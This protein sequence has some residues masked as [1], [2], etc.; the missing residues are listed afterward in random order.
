MHLSTDDAKLYY[1]R[2]Y[3][4]VAFKKPMQKTR[5]MVHRSRR[6]TIGVIAGWQFYGTALTMSYLSPIYLGIRQAAHDMGCNLLLACGMG[7]SAQI[8]D[9]PQPAWFAVAEGTNFVPVGPWNTHGLIVINPLQR[10]ER[11]QMV[12]AIRAAGHPIIFVGSGEVGPT[13][14][15]DNTAGIQQALHHLIEHGHR[16]IA[17]IAGSQHDLEGDTGDRLRAFQ[18]GMARFGIEVDPRLI[19]FGNHVFSGGYSAMKRLLATHVPFTAVLASNDESALGAMAALRDHGKRIPDD[20]VII[21]FD[22]R[23]EAL[24]A[25][26]A[27]TSVQIPL[28]KL[29]YQA[30]ELMVRHIRDR[31][32]LPTLIQVPTRLI[33][34]ESCGCSQNA[35]LADTL[36]MITLQ[37]DALAYANVQASVILSMTE[38]LGQRL[39]GF[40]REELTH[41]CQQLLESFLASVQSADPD[42]FR[43][44][45][46]R[47][48][49]QVALTGAD[50]HDWQLAIS[51]LRDVYPRLLNASLHE[52]AQKLLDEARITISSAMRF[53][54]WHYR[55]GQQQISNRVGR[56]TARLL[57]ALAESDIYD[58]LAR[59]LPELQI[60][61]LWIGFFETERDDP[62]AW[63]RLR[64]ITMPQQPVIRIRSRTFPPAQWLDSREPFRLT[65]IPLP[66]V[67]GEAGFVVFDCAQLDLYGTIVQ[68]ISAALNAAQLHR[69]ANEG[70]RLAEEANR[71]KSRFLSMVSH[72][73]Q[74]PLNL[75]VGMSDLLLRESAEGVQQLPTQVRHDLKRIHAHA[76]HLSRLIGD[77]LDL[78]SS[79]AGQLRL[80]YEVVDVGEVMRAVA[81]IGRQMAADKHLVWHDAIPAAGPWVWGDRTRLHQIALNL[82][83]NAIKFTSQGSVSLSV[84]TEADAVTISVRDTGLGLSAAEQ[85]HIFDEFQRSERSIERGYSGIGLGLAIC[86][87]L[88]AL[89]GGTI[90]VHSSGIEGE[91]STFFFRLPTIARPIG[92]P[93][94]QPSSV[95]VRPHVLLL[96]KRNDERLQHYL[97]KRGFIVH[98]FSVEESAAWL[99]ELSARNYSAVVLNATEGD[100]VW[101]Q[102][103][104][105]LKANPATRNLPLLCYGMSEHHGAIIELNYLTKPIELADL[106][107]V[108]DQYWLNTDPAATTYTVLVVDDDPDTLELHARIVQSHGAL[109]R[110]LC[111]RS[112]REALNILHQQAVHLV[113]L[114]LMMPEMDG[115]TLLQM[116]REHSQLREIPVIVITGHTLTEEDMARLSQ[117]VT[118]VLSK[119]MFS[120]SETLAH[121]QTALERRRRLSDQAQILVRKAM[122]Y[123]HSYYAHPIT[124][125]DIAHY[126]GMSEDYLTHCFRQEL[127]TTPVEYLNRYRVLQA[128]RLLVESDKSITNIALEVGFS[129]SSYFSRVFRKEVGL[130]PE[131][132]RR[133]GGNGTV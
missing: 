51:F 84:T 58:I 104:R 95:S 54:H 103:V 47:L 9:P 60:P 49:Q 21:G 90:G 11:S 122:A 129:S 16:Q 85:A 25:E 82:V 45:L 66:R 67:D 76:R 74:T 6:P 115:F 92:K 14:V 46:A 28:F 52:R 108:L 31:E 63:C 20:V 73:L 123:I 79:D 55:Y 113:L 30:L 112:G 19:V 81:D 13:I 27:L 120:A 68:Q 87:R 101:W 1:H 17:F 116:M 48:L 128:R 88:V 71:L 53:Q 91:G 36:E 80:V 75:I 10:P 83:V 8:D 2:I 111:A 34:R 41:F 106:T 3:R 99:S 59:Y 131:A 24:L 98:F 7:P 127:G 26:P 86:K 119:G 102:T 107:R 126:V 100:Q 72:E 29:G 97:E 70:R 33:I 44:T 42:R 37:V 50:A 124:R 38:L 117:G 4:H 61:L 23:P 22:D 40:T 57:T 12:Q 96:S 93:R 109:H 32:L 132:Y 133:L 69:T 18:D 62:V 94:R 5:A 125:Q 43:A 78:T 65:L 15:A 118:T 121:L 89:H 130:S 105:V 64:A 56:L 77:V 35:V 39:H 110:V 114:D